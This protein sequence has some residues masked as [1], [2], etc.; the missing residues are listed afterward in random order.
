[1]P[2]SQGSVVQREV[3]ALE[4]D[5]QEQAAS[6]GY[7]PLRALLAGVQWLAGV[8]P[9]QRE[10]CLSPEEFHSV[11]GMSKVRG[12]AIVAV[13]VLV[14]VVVVLAVEVGCMFVASDCAKLSY[15][16]VCLCLLCRTSSTHW[17]GTPK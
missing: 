8:P 7:F 4:L 5:A 15:V 14:V 2:C 12:V 6:S 17:I 3:V 9:A 1:M 11:F 10:Q 16:C 13:V